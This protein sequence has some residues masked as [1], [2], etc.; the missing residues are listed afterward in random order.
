MAQADYFIEYAATGSAPTLAD[1]KAGFPKM[2]WS[3][4]DVTEA[5][6]E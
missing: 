5:G 4:N 6:G 1:F 3:F 2:V